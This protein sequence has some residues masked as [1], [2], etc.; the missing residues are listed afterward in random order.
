MLAHRALN[1]PASSSLADETAPLLGSFS[2]LALIL[3]AVGIYSVISYSVERRTHE[4]GIRLALGAQPG[5][6]LRLVV[7]QGMALTL[8]GLAVGLGGA[9]ALTRVLSKFLH[10]VSVTD[11]A[12]FALLS[13]LLAAVALIAC[14]VPARRATKI[15]PLVALRR[16]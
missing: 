4:I 10:E 12:T 15:D 2:A 7:G 11:P 5:A 13:F 3:A 6:V 9:F 16:E 14:S 8:A 1:P